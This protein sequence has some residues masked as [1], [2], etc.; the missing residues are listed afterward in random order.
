LITVPYI[1]DWTSVESE[2]VT[3]TLIVDDNPDF[4]SPVLVRNGLTASSCVI[5]ESEQ[6]PVDTDLFWKVTAIGAS[7]TEY[8]CRPIDMKFRVR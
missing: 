3:Y 8:I 6:L 7:G 2:N 1:L 5:G 4:S